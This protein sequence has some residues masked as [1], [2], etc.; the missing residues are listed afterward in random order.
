[1][2]IFFRRLRLQVVEKILK[3]PRNVFFL[4]KAEPKFLKNGPQNVET[5]SFPLVDSLLFCKGFQKAITKRPHGKTS[6]TFIRRAHLCK[7]SSKDQEPC[8]FPL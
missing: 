3:S 1:M 4:L 8:S 7:S 6:L 2:F 5:A